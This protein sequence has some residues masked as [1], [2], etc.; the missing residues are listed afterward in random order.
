MKFDIISFAKSQ[1]QP[2]FSTMNI[3]SDLF[4]P[5]STSLDPRI[6]TSLFTAV[7]SVKHGAEL[8]LTAMGRETGRL[9]ASS[10]KHAI[11]RMDRLIGNSKL[12]AVR[13]YFYQQMASYFVVTKH[14]L[15]HIDWST[16]YNYN[17]V[18]LRAAIS[19]KGRAVT[20]YEEVHPQAKHGNHKVHCEFLRKLQQILPAKCQPIICTDSGFKIPWFK[21]IESQDWYW[22]G[23]TRGGTQ[24][25]LTD[26][27][28]WHPVHYHHQNAK[29]VAKELPRLVL[30]KEHQ[31]ECRGVLYKG[32][33]KNRH[34][35]N[36]E[37]KVTKCYNNQKHAKSAKEP[38]FLVSNLPKS[39][40]ETHQLVNFYRQ[41]MG[42]EESFRDCK[43]EYYGLGLKR[44]R[45]RCIARLE[46]ILLIGMLALFS[47]YM[48]GKAAEMNGYHRQ[49]QANTIRIRRV[50]SYS[51]LAMRILQHPKY[52]FT[53]KQ[54]LDAFLM[55]I[56]ES[57]YE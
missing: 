18:M 36:R 15:I 32:Q 21:A 56:E 35:F 52:T 33:N 23:R 16:V 1:Q 48:L 47:L 45:T 51:F 20:L 6:S 11:K 49:F 14:P 29:R 30:S 7:E 54:L 17:F 40:F 28:E 5:N 4:T 55:L 13:E 46:C 19:I 39:Q 34:N 27:V 31:Y 3:L 2:N 41:R 8:S 25:Q 44:S 12:H 10:E 38:W 26:K 22:L 53:E 43:N 9:N 24:C 57:C 50:L 37:G 42:I